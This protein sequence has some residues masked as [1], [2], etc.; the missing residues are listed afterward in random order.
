VTALTRVQR[1]TNADLI[2]AAQALYPMDGLVVDL[3]PGT[4]GGFWKKHQPDHLF[5]LPD[6]ADFRR[7]HWPAGMFHHAVFDPPYVAKGGH[8]TS[9]IH[10]MNDRYGMLHVEKNPTLQWEL[11]IIPGVKEAH[12]LLRRRGLLWWKL[13]DY[14]TAGRTHWFTKSALG[15][16]DA[17]GFEL[18]DGF[19]LDGKPGPQPK[20]NRDGTPRRQVHARNAHSELLIARKL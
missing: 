16:L 18:V 19:I 12:R 3:T 17:I 10:E 7:T 15:E 1:G 4:K 20:M 11:Q 9:T 14:V 6:S 5:L 13:Q 2:A 8:K